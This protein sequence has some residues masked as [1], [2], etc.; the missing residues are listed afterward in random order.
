[1]LAN[2]GGFTHITV[3]NMARQPAFAYYAQQQKHANKSKMARMRE[4]SKKRWEEKQRLEEKK[5]KL[6][7]QLRE[8]EQ[9]ESEGSYQGDEMMNEHGAWKRG[10]SINCLSCCTCSC[11]FQ[12][13]SSIVLHCYGGVGFNPSSVPSIDHSVPC[14][15]VSQFHKLVSFCT[16]YFLSIKQNHTK[17][18][19]IPKA[20]HP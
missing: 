4:S 1:M 17:A 5:R 7:Q 12:S 13:F 11:Q 3:T 9:Y 15:N 16:N 20:I 18:R 14:A 2:F 19:V 6:E 8:T 10:N